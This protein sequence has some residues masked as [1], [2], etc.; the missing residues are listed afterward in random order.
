MA[1]KSHGFGE[2][3]GF[4]VA[5][6][7]NIV[8]E[9]I[10]LVP[11]FGIIDSKKAQSIMETM[12]TKILDTESKTIILDILGVAAMD[13]AIA[14]HILK[15]SKATRLM[16]CECIVSGISPSIAQTLVHLGVDLGQVV[17]RAT[18]KDALQFAF[19]SAGLELREIREAQQQLV[20]KTA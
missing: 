12:L 11:I 9:G 8:W 2:S 5:T 16:G 15:I 14:N 18:L 3:E 20:K 10:L 19:K 17:T 6:P 13:S 7:V 1:K 4:I